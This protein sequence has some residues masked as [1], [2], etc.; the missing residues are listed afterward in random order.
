[1][2]W[3]AKHSITTRAEGTWTR[4]FW[5]QHSTGIHSRQLPSGLSY[6][7][8]SGLSSTSHVDLQQVVKSVFINL[9]PKL[10]Y[11]R[12]NFA[13]SHFSLCAFLPE[14]S[15]TDM[16]IVNFLLL[17]VETSSPGWHYA[18]P[19][20]SPSET[21]LKSVVSSPATLLSFFLFCSFIHSLTCVFVKCGGHAGPYER[22]WGVWRQVRH[23]LHQPKPLTFTWTL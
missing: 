11:S 18:V 7:S 1:M 16:R 23:G 5:R 15:I 8:L 14:V 22:G 21:F 9:T 2:I 13:I 17:K 19:G 4:K 3:T 12:P 20:G 10:P 6:H